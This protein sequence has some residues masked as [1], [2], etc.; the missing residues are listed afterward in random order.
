MRRV[1]V[2]LAFTFGITACD[3]EEVLDA[4]FTSCTYNQELYSNGDRHPANSCQVCNEYGYWI[5]LPDGSDCDFF[6]DGKCQNGQCT[7]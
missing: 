3:V 7:D 6:G 1:F 4:L 5:N 2:I